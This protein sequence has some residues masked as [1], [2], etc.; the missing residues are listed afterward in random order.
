MILV[1]GRG[2]PLAINLHSAS[3]NEVTLIELLLEQRI[4][5]RRIHRLVYDLVA[6]SDPL[7]SRLAKRGIDLITPH[8][9]NR[10]KPATQDGRKLRRYRKR[11]PV[12]RSFSW[13][14]NFR[15]L[16]VRYEYHPHLFVGFVQLACLLI[17]LRKLP[18]RSHAPLYTAA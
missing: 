8:R 12:E 6:D 7:R 15:R 14:H 18:L 5:N 3:P 16:V 17:T 13:F 1:D 10:I 11:W 2:L 4:L 9:R